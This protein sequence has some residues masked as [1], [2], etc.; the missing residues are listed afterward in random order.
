MPIATTT[1]RNNLADRYS[2]EALY[3]SLHTAD[4]DTTGTSEVTGG[5]PAYARKAITWSAPGAGATVSAIVDFDVP[6]NTAITHVGTWS[7]LT[8][9][10]FLDKA[11]HTYPASPT[12]SVLRI[13]LRY[14][15][16]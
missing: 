16:S 6:A 4:P 3:V 11:V 10:T 7:A 2:D 8:G 9:G 15:Q 13:H 5:S 12:Q 14:E 1:Q